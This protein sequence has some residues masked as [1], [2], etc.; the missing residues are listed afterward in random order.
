MQSTNLQALLSKYG[1]EK[2]MQLPE[3]IK[4][5]S[6]VNNSGELGGQD[7]ELTGLTGV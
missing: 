2:H 5:A 6:K 7:T 1:G 3:H 4:A